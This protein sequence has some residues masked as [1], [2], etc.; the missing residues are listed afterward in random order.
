MV[1]GNGTP[2]EICDFHMEPKDLCCAANW[3][4][5]KKLARHQKQTNGMDNLKPNRGQCPCK[6][7]P[8]FL[9]SFTAAEYGDLHSLEKIVDKDVD[10]LDSSGYTPLHLAAQNGHTAL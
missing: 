3:N 4:P 8:L 10:C 1:L 9:S 5:S 7:F 2:K 6:K